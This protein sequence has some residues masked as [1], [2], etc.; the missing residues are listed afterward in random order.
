M[1][2]RQASAPTISRV[3]PK[4]FMKHW[5]RAVQ[6][7]ASG[8]LLGAGLALGLAATAQAAIPAAE[9]NV[10]IALY[11]ST[12]GDSWTDNT[13]WKTGG[14]F[15]PADTECSWRGI[16]C[17]AAGDRVLQ[18]RLEHNNLQGTLPTNLK[19][20]TALEYF[21]VG[22][23]RLSGPIP[24]LS[25]M[26]ALKGFDVKVNQL[27]GPLPSL[28][29]LTALL[30][31]AAPA[32]QLTGPIPSLSGLTA[33]E[34]FDVASNQLTGPIPSLTGLTA[35]LQFSVADNRLTGSIPSLANLTA[36]EYF[37][38]GHNQLSGSIPSLAGLTALEQFNVGLNRLTGPIP[39]LDGLTALKQFLVDDNQLSGPIPSLDGLTA[40][41]WF[42]ADN[43]QLSGPIPS[44]D[45]LT[46]L[47]EFVVAD[48]QLTGSI[49]SLASLTALKEFIVDD[50]Q[51]TGP[52]PSLANLTALLN[53]QVGNNQLSGPG[54]QPP[55]PSALIAVTLC[56]NPLSP[57]SDASVNAFWDTFTS[58]PPWYAG[59]AGGATSHTITATADPIAAG[60][61]ICTP[62][63][64][65]HNGSTTCTATANP[66]YVF[67][68]FSGACQGSNPTCTLTNVT[69]PKTVTAHFVSSTV[70]RTFAGTTAPP[71]GPG[72][73]AS[74]R[75][76]G[77][78]PNCAFE[79]ASTAFIPAPATPPAGRTLPQG[80]FKFA[81]V[82]CDATPVTMRVT[83]PQPV[84]GVTKYGKATPTA[85]PTYFTPNIASASGYVTEI[86]VIDGQKGDDDWA[87]NGTILDPL[88]PITGGVGG[89][90]GGGVTA[91]PTLS[92]WAL[93]L[94]G[95]AAAGL[96]ARRLR[97]AG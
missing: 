29:D 85:S 26:T 62:S 9:R 38:V 43:N 15:S 73:T 92:E 89:G 22:Q 40:L 32:N 49:P 20:L 12:N 77:G 25:G 93:M 42:F 1:L 34:V 58:S 59:C 37:N 65:P 79:A 68:Q 60:A 91:V 80:M 47:Q 71:S 18:V 63:A 97:R 70:L 94:L 84:S 52:I 11:N 13:N 69:S 27:T 28:S 53:L 21:N 7:A 57:N 76:T 75:F 44:L 23:N 41:T 4:A 36:L 33:L 56:P 35:L 87:V 10:L 72:G 95:L 86:V 17:N 3:P 46:A 66:G 8:A 78:G 16:V 48:N 88:G 67:D 82:N 6:R 74:A 54:P 2:P 24:S 14:A 39:S 55:S 50:N 81:L 45:G 64:V 51:L 61:V 96:G 90:G 30:L 5:R 19:D 83:W 31:F